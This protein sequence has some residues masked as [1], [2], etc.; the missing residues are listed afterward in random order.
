MVTAFDSEGKVDRGHTPGT[1][2]EVKT[3]FEPPRK[4]RIKPDEKIVLR[5]TS[6]Q[7]DLIINETFAPS[8]LTGRLRLRIVGK[9]PV[10]RFTLDELD[11]LMG[12]V[13]AEANHTPDRKL[14]RE[15]LDI[16]GRMEELLYAYTDE[17]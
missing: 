12:Y 10:Y 7:C 5:L 1:R 14:E 6:R 2:R 3:M 8:E 13:A 16:F 9:K 17:D 4:K 11:E 15:L